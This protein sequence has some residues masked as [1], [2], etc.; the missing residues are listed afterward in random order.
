M[1]EP[2]RE[3][4]FTPY[5]RHGDAKHGG[6]GLGLAL[7]RRLVEAHGGSIGVACAQTGGSRFHF[8]LPGEDS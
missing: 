6:V 5:V 4:I 2:D 3:R 8:T 7:C 1:S